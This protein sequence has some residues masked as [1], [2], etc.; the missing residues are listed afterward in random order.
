[1]STVQ[2]P[3]TK[4]FYYEARRYC[5]EHEVPQEKC[6]RVRLS[7]AVRELKTRMEPW[8]NMLVKHHPAMYSP[9]L[10]APLPESYVHLREQVEK[11]RAYEAKA[12]SIEL[13]PAEAAPAA[14]TSISLDAAASARIG[15]AR[16]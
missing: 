6:E 8:M 4:A 10:D 11:I 1:M 16:W 2:F 15:L 3:T 14:A 7:M 12:L 5:E 9:D 13:A